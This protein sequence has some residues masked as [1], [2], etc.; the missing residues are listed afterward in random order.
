MD[1][2]LCSAM[3]ETAGPSRHLA[4]PTCS[5]SDFVRTALRTWR[6]AIAFGDRRDQALRPSQV[7][8]GEHPPARMR[9]L[10]SWESFKRCSLGN[11]AR[12][13]AP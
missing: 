12:L 5:V 11:R 3:G 1:G 13:S 8:G 6:L 4:P 2:R 9:K 7:A 10:G